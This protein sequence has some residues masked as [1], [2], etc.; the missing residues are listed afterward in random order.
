MSPEELARKSIDKRLEES[1]WVVQDMKHYNPLASLGVAVREYPTSTGE[2][3]YALFINQQPVGV[4]EA[5]RDEEGENMTVVESQSARYANSTM[6]Y[7]KRGCKIRFAYEATGKLTFF[8]DYDDINYCSRPVFS[9]H[10]PETL[11][12]LMKKRDTLRN[13]LKQFPSLDSTG[14]RDCQT[15][16]IV[17]LDK[18]FADNRPRALVQMATGAGKTFTAITE[19]YRLLKYGKMG[20]ILFLCDT[21]TLCKQAEEEFR[22]YVPNDDPRTFPNIYGVIRLTKSRMPPRRIGIHQHH[23]EN[24][25]HSAGRRP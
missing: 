13:R 5:K 21:R 16:A 4:I 10:R 7:I 17:E 14:F 20:R 23:S 18:S 19:V 25:F 15:K 11:L 6:K 22:K 24:V 2:V 1:G 8:T 3:D 12:E 9:F